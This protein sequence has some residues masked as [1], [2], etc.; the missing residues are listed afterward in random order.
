MQVYLCILFKFEDVIQVFLAL[1][2]VSLELLNG[3][4]NLVSVLKIRHTESCA[5]KLS[6]EMV[7]QLFRSPLIFV[8]RQICG[9]NIAAVQHLSLRLLLSLGSNHGKKLDITDVH[10]QPFIDE[11][12]FLHS[13]F[14]PREY[15]LVI[16]LVLILLI[17][18]VITTFLSL[19]MIKSRPT[20]TPPKTKTN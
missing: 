2:D 12:H 19:A 8:V 11:G 15:A 5:R 13:Y 20:Y 9:A 6:R 18:F 17:L 1:Q 14:L 16:P 10:L 4:N 3:S 7:C